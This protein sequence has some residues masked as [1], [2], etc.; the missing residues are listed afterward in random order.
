MSH[1][2]LGKRFPLGTCEICQR[3]VAGRI[4]AG[5]DGTLVRLRKHKRTRGKADPWCPGLEGKLESL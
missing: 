4:P 5:G 2:G 1:P 3:T